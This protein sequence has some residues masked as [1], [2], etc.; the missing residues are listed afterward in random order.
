MKWFG[1][2]PICIGQTDENNK[3]ISSITINPGDEIPPEWQKALADA[4]PMVDLV[5]C[6]DPKDM[7]EVERFFKKRKEEAH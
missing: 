1:S 2:E 3:V 4:G 6:K 7:K 5:P